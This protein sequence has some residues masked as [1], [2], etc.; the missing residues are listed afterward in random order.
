MSTRRSAPAHRVTGSV[1]TGYTG[2]PARPV[3]VEVDVDDQAE[4][5]RLL[6]DHGQA[7]DLDL[8]LFTLRPSVS[9]EE[10]HA[11]VT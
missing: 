4:P 9:G 11:P 3:Y 8:G 2:D 7:A 6:L 1:R 5:V 10:H